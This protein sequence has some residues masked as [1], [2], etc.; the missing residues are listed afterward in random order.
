MKKGKKIYSVLFGKCPCC[1]SS[2]VFINSNPYVL[3]KATKIH[4]RCSECGQLFEPEPS[5]YTGAM[6]VSYAFSVAIV[7][8]TFLG[9]HILFKEPNTSSMIFWGITIA[10]LFAPLNLRWSRMIWFNVF[11]KY[12]PSAIQEYLNESH[13]NK[14]DEKTN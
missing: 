14:T 7:L 12:K 10:V 11:V 5:F 9:S 8:G 4:K 3:S 2:D 13:E 1:H 6:Y